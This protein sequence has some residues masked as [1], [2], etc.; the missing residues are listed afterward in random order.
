LWENFTGI[1]GRVQYKL[2][3]ISLVVFLAAAVSLLVALRS[4]NKRTARGGIYFSLAMLALT[5]WTI[6]SGLGYAAVPVG[7]KVFYAKLE[8][9]GYMTGLGLFTAFALSYA[10]YEDWLKKAWVTILLVSLPAVSI[11]LAF[12][13]DLHGSIWVDFPPSPALD[14]AVIFVHGP[15]FNWILFSGYLL[16]TI[17]F[18]AF[19]YAALRGPE[20][21]RKQARLLVLAQLVL[22]GGNLLYLIDAFNIPG[23]DWSSITFALTSILFLYALY[24]TRFL[25]VIPVARNTMIERM[26]DA[27]LVLDSLGNLVDANPQARA[28]LGLRPGDLWTP[29][30]AA[31][32]NWPEIIA[33]LDDA[34][35][36][37]AT[38]L[39]LEQQAKTF[40]LRLT[41]LTDNFDRSYGLLVVMREITERK[42][43]ESVTR[44]RLRLWE[45][46]ALLPVEQ[47][48]QKALDE[49]G[50][51]TAS[52]IGFYHAV[53]EDQETLT[54]QAWSTRTREE[55]C[56]ADGEGRHY[57]I[58]QA[59]VWVDCVR[60]KRA[61][62][63][64]DYASLPHRQGL[65]EGHA[66]VI[67]ELAVPT[68]RE[69]RVVSILG[70]GNKPG[71]YDQKDVELVEYFADLLWTVV[72]KKRAEEHIRQLNDRLEQQVMT[73][74]L[75]GLANRRAFFQRGEEEIRRVER[76]HTPLSVIVLDG[77]RFKTINDSH[78]HAA[79]DGMLQT[80]ADVLRRTVRDIDLSARFG[81]DEFGILL[82]NTDIVGAVR[83]AER[84]RQAI[85][86]STY[87]LDGKDIHVTVSVGVAEYG[88]SG[89]NLDTILRKADAALYQAKEQGRDRVIFVD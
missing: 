27:V 56:K 10:G 61:V 48:M 87:R 39:T 67:R 82:P 55:F 21:A 79:G 15:G 6:V 68:L 72:D 74:D 25:D 58:S 42:R 16:A 45:F 31:L 85:K 44:M 71:D 84:L 18:G 65:P 4:W 83:L 62:I 47:L 24:N 2:T 23:L 69:G 36:P 20:R 29:Y 9:L 57:P 28:V 70:V 43:T 54:L 88:K 50:A 26:I 22:I 64:N 30:R 3:P 19:V 78:G 41:P 77:D 8:V 32:K 66:P 60:E 5:F 35:R 76:Y 86:T 33:L 11:L 75:T 40:D 53:D 52:P 13:N 89:K 51:L 38:E 14:N 73:D 7:L 1:E 80:I 59:G 46:A 81:G 34:D 63:H 49:I 12:T 17:V 37:E